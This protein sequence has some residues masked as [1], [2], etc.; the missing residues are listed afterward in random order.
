MRHGM[1]PSKATSRIF[2]KSHSQKAAIQEICLEARLLVRWG[3]TGPVTFFILILEMKCH[4]PIFFS[5]LT[6]QFPCISLF[7]WVFSE[8]HSSA[9]GDRINPNKMKTQPAVF[10]GICSTHW[11]REAVI[12]PWGQR[13]IPESRS[14]WKRSW[15]K[16]GFTSE[17]QSGWGGRIEA[18]SKRHQVRD[19]NVRRQDN[20]YNM[21]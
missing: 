7:W 10:S 12:Q 15:R 4:F 6:P 20:Q 2:A 8:S 21:T 1:C 11:V 16:M 18:T 13:I 5:Y 9:R 3:L 17:S 19:K 14:R